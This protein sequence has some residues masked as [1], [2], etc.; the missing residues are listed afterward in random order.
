[1]Q[2]IKYQSDQAIADDMVYRKEKGHDWQWQGAPKQKMAMVNSPAATSPGKAI[3]T[4]PIAAVA[5]DAPQPAAE[6]NMANKY[7]SLLNYGTQVKLARNIQ[8]SFPESE[9]FQS[10]TPREHY[11][12]AFVK[13]ILEEMNTS[14]NTWQNAGQEE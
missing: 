12:V 5:A 13:K 1:M 7:L 10:I 8:L 4:P 2:K 3:P 14:L 9:N 6:K 11:A